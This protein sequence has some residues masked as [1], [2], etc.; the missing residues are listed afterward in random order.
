MT[1]RRTAAMQ[2]L[3]KYHL[4]GE[5]PTKFFC[6]MMKTKKKTAQFCSLIK[7]MINKEG[8]EV[9]EILKEQVAIEEEIC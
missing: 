1:M 8:E 7:T 2:T 6:A 3:A 4:K 9:K 5:Q